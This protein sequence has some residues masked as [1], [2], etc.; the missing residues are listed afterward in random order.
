MFFVFQIMS[1]FW[2]TLGPFRTD[3][4][5]VFGGKGSLSF[6]PPLVFCIKTKCFSPLSN[7]KNNLIFIVLKLHFMS[8]LL[9]DEWIVYFFFFFSIHQNRSIVSRSRI[10]K[11]KHIIYIIFK[12]R[13]FACN[14]Y[15]RNKFWTF[16]IPKL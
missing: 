13:L 10:K 11:T 7:K 6:P 4:I 16:F 5:R 14:Y 12:L 15:F 2:P 8:K 1:L 9:S 3:T